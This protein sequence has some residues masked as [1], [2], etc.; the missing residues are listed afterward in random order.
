MDALAC[1][2][3]D[4]R[5]EHLRYHSHLTQPC[6]PRSDRKPSLVSNRS[7]GRPK[8]F[9]EGLPRC[10]VAGQQLGRNG[11]ILFSTLAPPAVGPP[12]S[13]NR[14]P[15]AS[16]AGYNPNQQ[17]HFPRFP[18]AGLWGKEPF[19]LHFMA[20]FPHDPV[21]RQPNIKQA[22]ISRAEVGE[23]SSVGCLGRP[24]QLRYHRD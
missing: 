19:E 7:L 9:Q 1:A 16:R 4:R 18:S 13:F 15:H 3:P 24:Q 14:P 20:P 8:A 21:N 23:T 11:A 10:F 6:K 12:I 2:G 5:A 17:Q 22:F